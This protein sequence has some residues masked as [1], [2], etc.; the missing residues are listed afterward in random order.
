MGTS[1]VL[2]APHETEEES[3]ETSSWYLEPRR[4]WYSSGEPMGTGRPSQEGAGA[5]LVD[6][7]GSGGG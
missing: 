1:H 3:E 5:K 6:R 2:P 4:H 7:P